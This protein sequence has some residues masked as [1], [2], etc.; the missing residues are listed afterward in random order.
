MGTTATRKNISISISPTYSGLVITSFQ[1][2][3][4]CDLGATT[5]LLKRPVD[6]INQ[7][8]VVHRFAKER[9]G[10]RL[11]RAAASVGPCRPATLQPGTDRK[12]HPALLLTLTTHLPVKNSESNKSVK[13]A[14]LRIFQGFSSLERA[15]WIGE[16]QGICPLT[17][18]MLSAF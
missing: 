7:R 11:M 17:L 2:R 3:D 18:E 14:A 10:P 16:F 5:G 1:S 12:I 15:S 8:L 4:L 6:C 9:H 13:V